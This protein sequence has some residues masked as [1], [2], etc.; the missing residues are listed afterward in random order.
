MHL[1][2]VARLAEL[3]TLVAPDGGGRSRVGGEVGKV[4]LYQSSTCSWCNAP[5]AATTT[6][7][8]A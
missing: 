6:L 1:V 7:G 5:A 8:A 3:A 4:R 2:Q